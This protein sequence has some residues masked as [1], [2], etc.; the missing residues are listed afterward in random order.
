ISAGGSLLT[1]HLPTEHPTASPKQQSWD[2][3]TQVRPASTERLQSKAIRKLILAPQGFTSMG[4]SAP[5]VFQALRGQRLSGKDSLSATRA[6]GGAKR[7]HPR[8]AARLPLPST[9][10]L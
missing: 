3:L 9:P 1:A 7:R 8:A 5:L 6:G 10:Y 4:F 2:S